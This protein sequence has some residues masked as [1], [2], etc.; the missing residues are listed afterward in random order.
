M[1]ETNYRIQGAT[2][3]WEVVIGL[4]VH[5]QITSHAKLFSGAATE[6][7]AEPNTQVSLIDAAMPGMLPVL[8]GECV[9]QAVRTGMAIN[10]QI[11]PWSRFDRKNYFYAD[12]PQG[13]QISQ[14][15]HPIVG[16]GE[17]A[18]SLDEKDA[19]AHTKVIGVERIHIEQDAGKLMHDQHPTMSYVDLN[20]CGV[21][22]ME[23]VSKPDMRSP[24][25]AGAY[26]KK[27]RSILRYVG[28][29]D[30]NMEEGSM[31]ADVNVSVRKPGDEFGTRTETK[32]VNSVRFI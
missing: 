30:G 3:E 6:F 27:L 21:A 8:N 29:C 15:Y 28:S 32:N 25:E 7:G 9:R 24:A 23:I 4:E 13:Y 2:G 1:T 17:I 31:R 20:R 26:V 5:A 16:E 22:L 12:L 10:A 11:N 14:L 19:D 18:I